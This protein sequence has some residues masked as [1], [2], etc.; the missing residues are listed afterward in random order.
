MLNQMSRVEQSFFRKTKVHAHETLMS[1]FK[2]IPRSLNQEIKQ[3]ILLNYIHQAKQFLIQAGD[4]AKRDAHLP[5]SWSVEK[6]LSFVI[7]QR[8]E[9]FA[10]PVLTAH[11]TEVLSNQALAEIDKIVRDFL[12]LEGQNE[13]SAQSLKIQHSLQKHIEK[14]FS[15]S[16]LPVENLT[17]EDEIIRQ[18]KIYLD[19]MESWPIFNSNNI[20]AFAKNHHVSISE[21]KQPLTEANKYSFQNVSS[22]AVADIDGNQKKSRKSMERMESGLQLAII[23]RFIQRV[24]KLL[25]RLPALQSAYNYLRRC[26]RAISDGIFFSL[27]GAEEAKKRLKIFIEKVQLSVS[28]ERLNKELSEWKDFID[29]VGFRG[30]LKQFVRQSSKVNADVFQNFINVLKEFHPDIQEL[31]AG[32]EHYSEWPEEH[33]VQL[34]H[35]LRTD[36]AFFRTLKQNI[37]QLTPETMR[38]LDVLDFVREYSDQFSY[39]LSDTENYGSLNEV[40]LLFGFS[41]YL[42]NKLY[43]DDIR[44][45]PVNLIPLCESPK[46]LAQLQHILDAMLSN[47]YL[48]QVIIN[49]GEIV[50]VAG[51]SDLGKEGGI[52]A[53]VEL[54]EA[55]KNALMI[56]EKHQMLDPE[57]KSVKLRVLYGLGT[58]FHRRVS[59]AFSQL[60]CTFQGSDACLLGS[61]GA[62]QAYVAGV[63]G[64]ASENSQRAQQLARIEQEFPELYRLM[65]KMI[66]G[67]ITSYRKFIFHPASQAL[68][69]Q[70]AIPYQLGILTNTSS[71]AESKNSAPKDINKSRAI[72][73]T[74]YDVSSLFMMRIFMSAD[75]LTDLTEDEL[76]QLPQ[77]Y[78]LSTVIKEQVMKI[79]YAIAVSDEFKA[80]EKTFVKIP[81]IQDMLT[82]SKA[83]DE[84]REDNS[85][86]ALSY[87][88]F[89]LPSILEVVV[90][91]LPEQVQAKV[92]ESVMYLGKACSNADIALEI[93]KTIGQFDTSYQQL[94]HE[95]VHQLRPA[96][97]RLVL[98]IN[99][100][101]AEIGKVSA[102]ELA[103]IEEDVVLALRGDKQLTSG[104]EAISKLSCRENLH[105]PLQL[106]DEQPLHDSLQFK[107][108]QSLVLRAKL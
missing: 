40:I 29:L 47:P 36:S 12:F 61:H 16:L 107:D 102:Q 23:D 62:Y 86:H 14:F 80:I 31:N 100:Y 78:Q 43:I 60:F 74:N 10:S 81:N 19:M 13:E 37:A 76:K 9:Y 95:I 18:D 21:I 2:T 42:K 93:I 17:P 48:K 99:K 38:E 73:I 82:F 92:S 1:I 75:G 32:F 5:I 15:S 63:T 79:L 70:L 50:Y 39:I 8:Q 84:M 4:L 58:D 34:H 6:K 103:L 101:D 46:D 87:A 22:W 77:L 67:S 27:N 104:P 90:R 25:P 26:Q 30:G 69:R 45:P 33:K 3:Q 54:I 44:R 24:E 96:Y 85:K 20:K 41:A 55:E 106:K 49:H 65:K 57:L 11:P 51:P 53:H 35:L 68:F 71:R 56:L 94:Y 108:E 83:F 7:Q 91:F 72:G 66:A 98:A 64:L 59:D 52:F 105:Y 97:Q 88:L 28:D 89:K